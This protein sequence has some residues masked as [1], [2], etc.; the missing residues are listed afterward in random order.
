[1]AKQSGL[2]DNLYFSGVDLSGDIGSVDKIS[3]GPALLDVTAIKQLAMNRIGGQRDGSI[4]FTSYFENA[5]TTAAPAV[6]GSGTPL[7]STLNW[8]VLVTI[9][10][11]TMSNVVINGVSVGTGAGTY[12]LP[13]LG[14]IT[15]TYTVAPTW[16]WTAI[17]TEHNVLKTPIP[18]TDDVLTYFRG[19]TIGNP[20]ACL[21][22][23][24][25][26]YDPTRDNSGGLT[27]KVSV[28]GNSFGLDWGKMLTPGLRTDT[29]ATTGAF[30]DL[31]QAGT[32]GWQ[33]YLQLVEFVGTSVDVTITHATTSGGSY[34]TLCDFGSQSV[35]NGYRQAGSGTV[36]EFVKVVTSG[37]FTYA[38]FAVVL[39]Q[40]PVAVVF[41]CGCGTACSTVRGCVGASEVSVT[42]RR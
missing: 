12:V 15:L 23:K 3:G 25:T 20:A 29:A 17:Q 21:V 31:G 5:G 36:N 4:D 16:T 34:T 27:L 18:G 24:Q 41:R 11:G 30:V 13:A 7:V 42:R 22:C 19:T 32:N 40:N 9:T 35:I 38:Q 28:V 14:T 33:A 37:T 39:V 10:G 2:G 8:S 6:P 1:M 26:N